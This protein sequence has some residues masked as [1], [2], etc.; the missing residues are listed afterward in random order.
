MRKALHPYVMAGVAVAGA[1]AL[2]IAPVIATPPDIKIVNP[3][4]RPT[5]SPFDAYR[6]AVEHVL[7]NLG[8]LLGSALAGPAPSGLNLELVL[9]SV[10]GDPAGDFQ[11][12]RDSLERN[13]DYLPELIDGMRT[14]T[15]DALEAAPVDLEAGRIDL[16]VGHL[17]SASVVLVI[18][19]ANLAMV[20]VGPLL[21]HLD[22]TSK[23]SE[24]T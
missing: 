13:V 7:A 5:A 20:P 15:S 14:R 10:F 19:V 24:P 4:V 9:D 1:A 23:I 3:E 6:D 11:A 8:A 22:M 16:A 2:S 18:Q 12:L 21:G 17:L